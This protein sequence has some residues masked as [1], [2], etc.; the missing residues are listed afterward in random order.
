M[1]N[2]RNKQ[3]KPKPKVHH[4]TPKPAQ[5]QRAAPDVQSQALKPQTASGLTLDQRR[6][7]HA[8]HQ[9]QSVMADQTG[10][11]WRSDYRSYV[12]GMPLALRINGLGQFMALQMAQS[13]GSKDAGHKAALAHILQWL[14]HGWASS[15]YK[16]G[17]TQTD[18]AIKHGK[19]FLDRLTGEDE[20]DM[21]RAQREL[22]AYLKWLKTFAEALI[23]AETD[24]A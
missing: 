14:G 17:A 15:P 10:I 1:S 16:I 8:L 9:V 6:A 22:M 19:E 12:R 18:Q 24:D 23:P 7:K 3:N 20:A 21:L 4:Q 11:S 13:S 2:Y 5:T